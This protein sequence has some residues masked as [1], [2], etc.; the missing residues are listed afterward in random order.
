MT[1]SPASGGS[2]WE[3]EHAVTIAQA[4]MLIGAQFPRLRHAPVEPLASGWD[5]T[6][7]LVDRRWVFRFPRREQAL[8]CLRH[9]T[10]VLP[11]LGP[12]LPLP[13]PEPKLIGEPSGDYPWPFWGARHLPGIELADSGLPDSGRVRAARELGGFLRVLHDPA[14]GA[15]VNAQVTAETGTGLPHDPLHRADPGVRVPL[16]RE[17]LQQIERLG[18][19]P[20]VPWYEPDPALDLLFEQAADLGPPTA[21]PVLVHGDLHVRHLLVTAAGSACGVID[22]GDVCLGD[23]AVDLSLGYAGFAGAARSAFTAAY[24]PIDPERE[25]R[26]R[27]LAVFL[28]AVL[29][30]YAASTGRKTLL[31]EALAGLRRSVR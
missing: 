10:A 5:N 4:E 18:R 15:E 25:L 13:V 29:A 19:R 28:S 23:P 24:G 17:R 2:G 11:R 9:E 22:W 14:L 1:T 30:D 26:A 6:V 27:T 16:A 12:H 31:D 8:G 3:A 21:D 20:E 7:F